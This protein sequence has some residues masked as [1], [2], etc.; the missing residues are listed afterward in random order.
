MSKITNPKYPGIR[1]ALDGNTAAIMCERES[2]DAAGAYPIT[3]STQMGEYWAEEAAKGHLNISNKPLIFIEP[4]GEHAAAAVTAGLSMT[5]QRA[6]NF[7]S[8]QGIAYMHES[9]YAAVGKRLTYVLNIGARAMTKSTLNVHAGHDDYHAVDDTGFFQMF[10]KNAQHVADLNILAHHIAE[11]ALTPGII[12][13]DGFLTT[14]LIESLYLPEREL[15][16]EFLG[17]PDDIIDTPT[18]AQ[19]IIFGEKRRRIPELWDVDNPVMAGIVQNQDSYMQ[20]VAAQRPFFFDHIKSI[21]DKAFDDYAELTG[22]QY[23]RVM[24]YKAEDADYLILGQGSLIPSAEAVADYLRATRKIKVGVVNLV[25]F[26]P[27]PSDLLSKVIKGKKGVVV[28][29]RV[30]QPLAEDLPIA[31]ELRAVVSKC[32]ENGL[33]DGKKPYP[34]IESYHQAKDVPRIYSGSFGMG[35]RDLQAE[36]IIGAVENMLPDGKQKK[37]FYLS[38]D[39]IRENAFT[40]KQRAHQETILEAYPNVKD[41]AIRGSE[42]PNLMPKGSTTVRFH[43]IG[44]WGAITTGKNLAMTLYDLLGFDIKANPKYGS[45]KKGQPTTYYLAAAPEP[46]RMNCEFYFVDVVLSPDPNVFKHTN[47]LAGLKEGGVFIIQ[48][49]K[50][51]PEEVWVD[52]P[53]RYQRLIIQNKIRVF[54]IDG[55]KIAR[56]E[57]TDPELQLRMQGIAFQGAFFAASPLMKT[58]GLNEKELLKAIED[59]LQHKFGA[60]GQ[61]VVDDNMRVVKRGFTEVHEI[62][63]KEISTNTN[64][65]AGEN[66]GIPLPRMLKDLPQSQSKLSDIHR[67]WEQTGNFYAQGMGNDNLTDPFIGLSVMPAT[68]AVFRDMTG[69]RF[70]HPEWV[71]N[72][73]TACGKCYTVCPDTAIPGLVSDLKDVLDTVVKRVKKNRE[74]VT[75]LTKL[76]RPLEGKVRTLFKEAPKEQTVNQLI[77]IAIDA[78]IEESK[79]KAEMVEE[80]GWFKDELGDFKFALTRPYFDLHEKKSANSGGLFS[81]TINPNTCKGCNECIKVCEDDALVSVIQTEGSVARLRKDW[82][83]WT[84]LPSTPEKFNRIDSLEEKIGPLETILLNKDAYQH[85]VSGDGACL[86]CSEKSVVHL[87]IATIESLMQPRIKKHLEQL[88]DL[89]QKLEQHIQTRLLE[90]INIKDTDAIQRILKEAHHTDLTMSGIASKLEAES[91]TKP[92][93]QDW[94]AE[95]TLLISQLR[96]LKW[97]YTEGTT[98]RGRSSMGMTNATGCTSVWGSTYP[99]NPYPFPWANHLF[100]DSTSMAMGIFEGHMS[101]MADGFKAIRKAN[102]ILEGKYRAEEHNDFFTYFNWKQ[103]TDEEWLLCPPVVA[104]GGDGAMYDIG[105]QNLSRMM[106]SGKPIKV[107]VVDTQV[108]SNTGG[109]ACTSGFIGQV[110]DMAQY[111]KVWKGKP[112]PRKEIGLIAMAHRNTYVMQGTLA[113]TSHMIEGFIDG[114]MTKRPALFNLYTTCQPEHGVADDLGS[115]QAKLAVESRAY[116]IFRYNPDLSV[117]IQEALDLSG[118]PAID[119]DW[120]TY[121]L[122]YVENGVEKSMEVPMTFADFALT[123]GRF[124]KH[125]RNAPPNT[126]NENM[127]LLTEFLDMSEE[128][129]EG[130]FPFIWA[131]DRKNQLTRVIVAK[132]IVE[133]CEERRDFWILLRDLAGTKPEEPTP[134]L[135]SKIRAEIVG[136]LARKLAQL[137][138]GN[139]TSLPSAMFEEKTEQAVTTQEEAPKSETGMSAWIETDECTSCNECIN[140]N[141]KIFAYNKDKKAYIKDAQAGPYQ[142]LV[143]AAEKCTAQV[144]HPGLPADSSGKDVEKWIKRAEK[145]N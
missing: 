120:P 100:Q 105:F 113:N 48:S 41:L 80:L 9:L 24:T 122:K 77:H 28:L 21:A 97:K 14:H 116:P 26:R 19:R 118:N 42:N 29:E 141:P 143:L 98:G 2:S 45:E 61:R 63:N 139:G 128:D 145:Y 73:C 124:R 62:L 144:I 119:Q 78:L 43:S 5:G 104:L 17:T 68:S 60:K 18:P 138:G 89:I 112:E 74:N 109:Q 32:L 110:S 59:Q 106:A 85:F 82:D 25:M 123:E 46:I 3:P 10:A 131:V 107:I 55:F 111:G 142:D 33:S 84:D 49:D 136:K 129:R 117:K 75:H 35:S 39:F 67:F 108:Y 133:S 36:G 92:I 47:A 70:E 22:R 91:G 103:F 135:E 16:K 79:D 71:P 81:I 56:E 101:K 65:Q 34:D 7:S 87:F 51:T 38:I 27:F 31:R 6:A 69:I 130:K 50:P 90:S 1:A 102:L 58:A 57:A 72:N 127:I 93:D 114:L 96:K 83:M 12:A 137:A 23:Q 140:L 52:I 8:G 95:T 115:H 86:G 66:V 125:F 4:E 121:E 15:I 76:V 64:G 37:L 53:K 40:P 20:S 13:Q 99:Y 54:Y 30:D 44:G 88:E 126:W 132:T 11:L 94:L 134:D